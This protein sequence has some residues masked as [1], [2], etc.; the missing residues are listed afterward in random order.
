MPIWLGF[1]ILI[2]VALLL[3]FTRKTRKNYNQQPTR[4]NIGIVFKNIP[5]GLKENQELK[6]AGYWY[7]DG[8]KT[9]RV[10]S[11]I[12]KAALTALIMKELSLTKEDFMIREASDL[13]TPPGAM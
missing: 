11:K 7:C 8:E 4:Y 10:D 5:I 1:L 13:Y 2:I 3:I 6:E 9:Y 12:D